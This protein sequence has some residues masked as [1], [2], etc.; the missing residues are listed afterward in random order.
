MDYSAIL[1]GLVEILEKQSSVTEIVLK[2]NDG[3]TLKF[4][5]RNIFYLMSA[6]IDGKN[7]N[8]VGFK[9]MQSYNSQKL[10]DR[11]QIVLSF[12]KALTTINKSTSLK[13]QVI[14]QEVQRMLVSL[15]SKN[16]ISSNNQRQVTKNNSNNQM[17]TMSLPL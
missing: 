17:N 8:Q 12:L 16:L 15:M 11:L 5:L 14:I 3:K 6:H 2:H 9:N 4:L 10:S 13:Q 1:N 7:D